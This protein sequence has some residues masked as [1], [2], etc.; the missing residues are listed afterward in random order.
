MSHQKSAEVIVLVL[1]N[2]EGLNNLRRI[3]LRRLPYT[4]KQT[5]HLLVG[6]SDEYTRN[7]KRVEYEVAQI[8]T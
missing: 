2:E 1:V 5:T 6:G 7:Y 3:R 4:M 8:R